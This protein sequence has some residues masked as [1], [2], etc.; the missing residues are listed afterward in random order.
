MS[1]SSE[2]IWLDHNKELRSFILSKIK[3]KDVSNDIL[4]DVFVKV[5][6]NIGTLKDEEVVKQ[7]VYQI[8]RNM[9]NDH[10]R[11]NKFMLDA[12]EID[13]PEIKSES[14]NMQFEKCLGSFV[15]ELPVIYKEAITQIELRNRSQL[16][17]SK[18]LKLSYSAT[19]SRVQRARE[20]LKKKFL[21]CCNVSTDKYGNVISFLEKN[22]CST[23][24]I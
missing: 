24:S 1:L 20:L 2:K 22:T 11:K 10:F 6:T 19:K 13:L 9:I 21:E 12:N 4:Q 7:W 8:T 23:C 16:D 3:D 15:K 14:N 18:E 5:H 17:L